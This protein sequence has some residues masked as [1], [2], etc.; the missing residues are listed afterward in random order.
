M[1]TLVHKLQSTIIFIDEVDGF[2]R[3]RRATDHE[4]LTNMKTKF[5]ALWDGFTT[6][7]WYDK[8]LDQVLMR[9]GEAESQD[10]K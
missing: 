3:H 1:F 6:N 7:P 5:M 9:K 8:Y 2:W 4:A 10:D